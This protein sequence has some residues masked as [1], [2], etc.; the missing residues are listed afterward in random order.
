[1]VDHSGVP[2]IRLAIEGGDAEK[3]YKIGLVRIEAPVR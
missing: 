1:M 3:R 2:R